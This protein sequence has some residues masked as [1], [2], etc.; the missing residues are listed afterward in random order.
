[1]LVNT[2][3]LGAVFAAKFSNDKEKGL[4]NTVV[5]MKSHGFTTCGKDVKQATYRAVYT[6]NN[7]RVQTNAILLNNS[8]DNKAIAVQ[9][10]TDRQV[11]GCTVFGDETSD[12][13]WGLWVREVEAAPLYRNRT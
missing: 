12:R 4:E 5:L 2:E 6:H 8:L 13:P 3:V 9:Y 1:M 11:Q 10:L 7:A